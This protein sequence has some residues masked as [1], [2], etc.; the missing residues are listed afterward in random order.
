MPPTTTELASTTTPD[1]EI[2]RHAQTIVTSRRYARAQT[3]FRPLR[4][5]QFSL[6]PTSLQVGPRKRIRRG[7]KNGQ[8]KVIGKQESDEEDL[9][10]LTP[11]EIQTRRECAWAR[12]LDGPLRGHVQPFTIRPSNSKAPSSPVVKSTRQTRDDDD[13]DDDA[14]ITDDSTPARTPS[15]SRRTPSTP[16]PLECIGSASKL[17]QKLLAGSE[18][19]RSDPNETL[20]S[21]ST[22]TPTSTSNRSKKRK[23]ASTS[24]PL[25]SPPGSPLISASARVGGIGHGLGSSPNASDGMK[26]RP[27]LSQPLPARE[28]SDSEP[29]RT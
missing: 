29:C 26:I 9:S 16:A 6:F 20:P 27:S 19:G 21:T 28:S 1:I 10:G 2:F 5:S 13:D 11:E 17:H 15:R 18:I 23:R 22:P 7:G 8:T 12:K 4:P 3:P 14:E 25:D 24:P